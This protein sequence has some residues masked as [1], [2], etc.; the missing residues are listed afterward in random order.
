MGEDAAG[1][2]A[3]LGSAIAGSLLARVLW[4]L[5]AEPC[6]PPGL[7]GAPATCLGPWE[8]HHDAVLWLAVLGAGLGLLL[9][10]V[11]ERRSG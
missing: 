11:S 3:V 5:L 8:S 10:V 4:A 1:A 9:W 6:G 7:R 2:S